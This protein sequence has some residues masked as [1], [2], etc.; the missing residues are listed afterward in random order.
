MILNIYVGIKDSFYLLLECIEEDGDMIYGFMQKNGID[1]YNY[2]R[3][4]GDEN[5]VAIWEETNFHFAAH[6]MR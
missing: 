2:F 1:D 4:V 3:R 6:S 5:E